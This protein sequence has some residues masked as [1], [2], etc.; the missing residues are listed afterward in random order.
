M[1]V[2][3]V[4]P[5]FLSSE[6]RQASE[7]S[8]RLVRAHPRYSAIH[9]A[10]WDHRFAQLEEFISR[11]GHAEVPRSTPGLG[12]WV[13]NQRNRQGS[14][15][16]A[17]RARLDSIGFVWNARDTQ[18]R[19]DAAWDEMFAQLEEYHRVHGHT[20]VPR[21][22]RGLGRWVKNQRSRQWS[23]SAARRARLNSIGFE[24]TR[25]GVR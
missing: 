20:N 12:E 3:Y 11:H 22:P 13:H 17:R 9:D 6:N 4:H 21:S 14:M 23:M 5:D 18:A 19:N 10:V 25:R 1:R 16:T 15:S 8:T 7:R 24:W 2:P